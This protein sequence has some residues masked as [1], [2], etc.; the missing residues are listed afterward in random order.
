M[1]LDGDESTWD[2][3]STIWVTSLFFFFFLQNKAILGI[4]HSKTKIMVSI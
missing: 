1:L 2:E 3:L 4:P